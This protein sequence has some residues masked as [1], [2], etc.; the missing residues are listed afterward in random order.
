MTQT[1]SQWWRVT[2][3]SAGLN[4][5]SRHINLS[6]LYAE[7]ERLDELGWYTCPNPHDLIE[8]C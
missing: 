4:W 1:R 6:R 2:R 5:S 7:S 3:S 8:A